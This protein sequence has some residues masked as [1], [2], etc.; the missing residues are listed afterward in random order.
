[1]KGIPEIP[2]PSS[3][4]ISGKSSEPIHV[5]GN[6]NVQNK[7]KEVGLIPCLNTGIKLQPQLLKEHNLLLYTTQNKM[8]SY[9]FAIPLYQASNIQYGKLLTDQT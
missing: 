6:M 2:P 7:E 5:K 9:I 1:M 4:Q 3:V 8:V